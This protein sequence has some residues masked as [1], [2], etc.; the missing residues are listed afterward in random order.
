MLIKKILFV[1]LCSVFVGGCALSTVTPIEPIKPEQTYQGYPCFETCDAFEKG[2]K[3][4]RDT[5]I[6][7]EGNCRMDDINERSGCKAY[8]AEAEWQA[9]EQSDLFI[10]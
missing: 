10:K 8:V 3:N 4:A 2:F 6:K 5:G 9:H 7:T 1:S